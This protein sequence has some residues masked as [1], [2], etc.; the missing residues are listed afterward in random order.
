MNL[1]TVLL[2]AALAGS[3]L[4]AAGCAAAPAEVRVQGIAVPASLIETADGG[5]P[6]RSQA[7]ACVSLSK[8]LWERDVLESLRYLR[9]G[10]EL[11]D[12][13]SCRQYLAHAETAQVNL[14]QRL[15]ARLFIEGLLRKGPVLA[16]GGED[17]RGELYY[18]LCW[19][20][21]YTEPRCPAKAKQVLE[22]M[23]E[24]GAA[25]D[26]AKS[27]FVVQL[28]RETGLHAGAAGS[29][30]QEIQMY[31]AEQA[32]ASK[33]WLQVPLA[34][35]RRETGDWAVTEA[36]AWGGGSDRLFLGANVLAFLVN[37]QGEPSFR[38][39]HLWICNLGT[40]PVDVT[41]LATGLSHRELRPGQEEVL[42]L[43]TA[44]FDKSEST[45]G[46]PLSVRHRRAIR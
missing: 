30:R 10:A 3:A 25:S 45:T 26:Q 36:N 18:Q 44:A 1:N 7:Q 11:R 28:I 2:A 13:E 9:K 8:K 38:G 37:A 15:Y 21:R 23:L 16:G 20:W 22:A 39:S 41:S 32:D 35:E 42:P 6:D 46:I 43:V 40:S 34:G 14:S 12:A 19:A 31:A 27:A 5:A 24:T 4:S 33:R 29:R 17:I